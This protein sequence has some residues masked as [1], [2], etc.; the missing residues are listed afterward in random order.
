MFDYI[1]NETSSSVS[2]RSDYGSIRQ[3]NFGKNADRKDNRIK[4]KWEE[5]GEN[6]DYT[7]SK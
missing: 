3:D 2:N 6:V 1:V 5:I 7:K 4:R